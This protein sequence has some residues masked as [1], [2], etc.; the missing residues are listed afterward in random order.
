MCV[1]IKNIHA[2]SPGIV[3]A[4]FPLHIPYNFITLH[5]EVHNPVTAEY[6]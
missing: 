1:K 6:A 3:P 4:N 5:A 2:V